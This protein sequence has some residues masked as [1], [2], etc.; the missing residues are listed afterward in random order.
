[1]KGEDTGKIWG[2][3]SGKSG[4]GPKRGSH[5]ARGLDRRTLKEAY[6]EKQKKRYI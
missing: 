2:K 1:M 6:R 3:V 4:R 5:V